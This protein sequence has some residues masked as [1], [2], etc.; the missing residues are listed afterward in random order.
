MLI[1]FSCG[2][3]CSGRTTT[4]TD[5]VEYFSKHARTR[6]IKKSEGTFDPT[7][8][9]YQLYREV[10]KKTA[11]VIIIDGVAYDHF[12]RDDMLRTIYDAPGMEDIKPASADSDGPTLKLVAIN[13]ARNDGFI[14]AH[15]NDVGHR[16]YEL[17]NMRRLISRYQQPVLRE[18]FDMIYQVRGDRYLKVCDFVDMLNR[19]LGYTYPV[20]RPDDAE[21][22]ELEKI[23]ND[24]KNDNDEQPSL[25]EKQETTADDLVPEEGNV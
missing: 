9:N 8:V 12:D 11:E 7:A 16:K 2:A 17:P 3:P 15:N 5:L 1:I 10:A 24:E 18:G 4:A 19:R 6:L 20:E 21:A 22:T 13:H 25:D 23:P 14:F